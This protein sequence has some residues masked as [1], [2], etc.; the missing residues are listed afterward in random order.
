MAL[1]RPVFEYVLA[2]KKAKVKSREGKRTGV[3]ASASG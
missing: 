2:S 1:D 3:L